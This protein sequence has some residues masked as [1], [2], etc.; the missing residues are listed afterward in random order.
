MQSSLN[1]RSCVKRVDCNVAATVLLCQLFC[2][3]Q[4]HDQ[5]CGGEACTKTI[6]CQ[7]FNYVILKDI[8]E[9]NNRSKE[10]TTE[11]LDADTERYY[12]QVKREKKPGKS[13]NKQTNERKNERLYTQA[14]YN[15]H[16]LDTVLPLGK[17]NE[18]LHENITPKCV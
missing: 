15:S 12:F 6:R 10:A 14:P 7:R 16:G 11:E 17:F 4:T 1:D 13:I 5:H 9:L 18:G 3:V 8:C 2:K